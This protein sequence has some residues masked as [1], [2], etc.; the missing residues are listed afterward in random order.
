M[1]DLLWGAKKQ[2]SKGPK[3]I[4][5][6]DKIVKQAVWIADTEGIGALS[7]NSLAAALGVG[8]MSLYRYVPNKD[9]LV[10]LMIDTVIG[11]PQATPSGKTW[12]QA[13]RRW[14]AMTLDI[15]DRHPWLLPL[16]ATPRRIG[17][18]ELA[19]GEI[20]LKIAL[21]AADEAGARPEEMYNVVVLVNSFV[22]GYAQMSAKPGH[23]PRLDLEAI[24]RSGSLQR[25]PML[26]IAMGVSEG[27][28]ERDGRPQQSFEFGIERVLDGIELYLKG[29]K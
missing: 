11:P 8:T 10:A 19:W 15:F 21:K 5:S 16:I 3:P 26:M 20:A 18:H 29:R 1:A 22:R 17:P 4:L 24:A 2:K 9:E 28:T 7:M 14:S 6:I 12:R 23:G 27:D 25:Y 13:M